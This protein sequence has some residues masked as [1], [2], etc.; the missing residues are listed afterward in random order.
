MDDVE[1]GADNC[2]SGVPVTR[3]DVGE[4]EDNDERRWPVLREGNQPL[5]VVVAARNMGAA[6]DGNNNGSFKVGL[7]DT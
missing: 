7:G 1:V 5:V 6:D 2:D 3:D 4:V